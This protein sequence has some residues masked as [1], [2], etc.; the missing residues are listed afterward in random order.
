MN[1]ASAVELLIPSFLRKKYVRE[2][3]VLAAII[4]VL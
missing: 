3:S 4:I 1:I 2:E